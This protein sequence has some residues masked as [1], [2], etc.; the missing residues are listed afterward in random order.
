M[1]RDAGVTVFGG[2]DNIRDSWSPYGDGDLLRRAMLIGYRS[3]LRTDADLA[4][5]FDMVTSAGAK[6]LGIE[7]YGLTVG[8][9][10]DFVVLQAAHVAEAVV[11][12]PKPRSVYKSGRCIARDGALLH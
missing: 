5:A 1:L 11:A 3:D 10:A 9:P 8:A 12:V 6:A 7:P 4:F 2:N